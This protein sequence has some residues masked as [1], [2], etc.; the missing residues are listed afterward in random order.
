MC[1]L[2]LFSNNYIIT[3][4]TVHSYKVLTACYNY[5]HA[6][7]LN[8]FPLCY[9]N[10]FRVFCRTYGA[11]QTNRIGLRIERIANAIFADL[12]VKHGTA[13]HIFVSPPARINE[14]ILTAM[15]DLMLYDS[16]AMQ[17]LVKHAAVRMCVR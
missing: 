2:L 17:V 13:V 6:R 10:P 15:I 9:D 16:I 5:N 3:P 7:T 4:F 8:I 12:F 14:H 11:L 1:R